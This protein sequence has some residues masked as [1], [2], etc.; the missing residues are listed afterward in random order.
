VL[1]A[2]FFDRHLLLGGKLETLLRK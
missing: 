2:S 1:L